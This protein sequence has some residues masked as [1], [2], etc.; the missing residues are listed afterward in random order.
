MHDCLGV[1]VEEAAEGRER[2][3][4][5]CCEGCLGGGEV[6]GET[7]EGC[8]K[9]GDV[10]MEVRWVGGWMREARE[11]EGGGAQCRGEEGGELRDEGLQVGE[12]R[13]GEE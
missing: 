6:G 9:R 5:G 8:G 13:V 11:G 12:G 7:G 2:A 3:E 1:E 4:T 10:P